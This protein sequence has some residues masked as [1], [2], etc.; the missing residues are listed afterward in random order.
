MRTLKTALV[1]VGLL[2]VLYGAYVV[3]NRP[4]SLPFSFF[5]KKTE[6]KPEDPDAP[7][8]TTP[9]EKKDGNIDVLRY[10]SPLKQGDSAPPNPNA[11]P[12]PPPE[13]P[14]QPPPGEMAGPGN[15]QF[16]PL[17]HDASNLPPIV[18]PHSPGEP[19]KPRGGL[20]PSPHV[21]RSRESQQV[22]RAAFHRAWQQAEEHLRQA[23][24]PDALRELTPFYN[25]S[26]LTPQDRQVLADLLDKLAGT[27]V[28]SKQYHL[29]ERAYKVAPGQKLG[30][31]ADHYK[32]P[33]ELL[34]RINNI[35]DPNYLYKGE[36]LKVVPGPFHAVVNLR[37]KELILLV[38][39][40]YAGRMPISLGADP[41][42]PRLYNVV[43]K[44]APED[45]GNP[46]GRTPVIDLGGGVLLYG[47]NG[48]GSA[49]GSIAISSRDATDLF[50]ILTERK[51]TVTVKR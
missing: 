15:P 37:D 45:P 33:W 18:P 47:D 31:I 13:F 36:E 19:E 28:Y 16:P 43:R 44:I 3:I 48:T 40:C 21:D 14:V 42:D 32:I 9:G 34:A 17:P 10:D 27:V 30:E 23:H 39:D 51:S 38:Q 26:D 4:G 12:L 24:Y 22:G 1:V 50:F 25:S 2:A 5:N 29:L 49:H 20:L 7:V 35:Q 41:V 6:E 11:T 8:V 46:A